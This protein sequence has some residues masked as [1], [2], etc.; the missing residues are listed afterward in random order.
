MAARRFMARARTFYTCFFS[1]RFSPFFGRPVA[2]RSRRPSREPQ[3]KKIKRQIKIASPN[4][5]ADLVKLDSTS[6]AVSKKNADLVRDSE[7]KDSAMLSG[8]NTF[9]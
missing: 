4:G 3:R 5:D 6:D 9:H 2:V 1:D 7:T 8:T